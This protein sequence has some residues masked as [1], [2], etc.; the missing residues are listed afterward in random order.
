VSFVSQICSI[1]QVQKALSLSMALQR[2]V[3]QQGSSLIDKHAIRTLRT[4]RLAIL[5]DG[6][7]LPIF[8]HPGTLS[9]LGLWLADALRDWKGPSLAGQGKKHLPLVLVSLNEGIGSFLVV[10]VAP[11]NGFGD[12]RKK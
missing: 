2:A 1:S 3:I 6:P 12:I 5:K 7:D 11:T 4:F 10:G 9:R 8:H